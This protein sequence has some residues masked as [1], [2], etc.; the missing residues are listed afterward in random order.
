M[1][2][3]KPGKRHLAGPFFVWVLLAVFA[4]L[5]GA[6]R[7]SVLVAWM[8]V[9]PAHVLST[10]VLVAVI[11]VV[12]YLYFARGNRRYSGGELGL[13]GVVWMLLTVGFEFLVGYLEG[14]STDDVLVQYDVTA[15]RI[16][17]LVS[18]ALL[19]APVIMG[20]VVRERA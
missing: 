15:G 11:L 17:V 18:V 14:A 8:G 9:Y 3:S 2:R 12:A 6:F 4:V 7:E 1:T 5:N 16:W 13:I 20:H 10:L 19:L